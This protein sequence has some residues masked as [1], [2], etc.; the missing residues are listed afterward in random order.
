[1]KSV[2]PF[3]NDLFAA[4]HLGNV[5]F[6]TVLFLEVGVMQPTATQVYSY[7]HKVDYFPIT[8]WHEGKVIGELL[9]CKQK[10]NYATWRIPSSEIFAKNSLRFEKFVLIQKKS[11][12]KNTLLLNVDN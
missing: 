3:N 2:L 4:M 5:Y 11:G 7:H 8:V 12:K 10:G 6:I 1:M 9:G